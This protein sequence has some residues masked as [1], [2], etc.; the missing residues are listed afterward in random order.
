[1][2]SVYSTVLAGVGSMDRGCGDATGD[3]RDGFLVLP[4]GVN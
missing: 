4:H 1:M 3:P 2:Q